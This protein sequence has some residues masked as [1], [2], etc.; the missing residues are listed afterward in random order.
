MS[1]QWEYDDETRV[2]LVLEWIACKWGAIDTGMK[3]MRVQWEHEDESGVLLVLE[4]S[5]CECMRVHESA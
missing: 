3:S 5:A 2:L 1:V 4:W